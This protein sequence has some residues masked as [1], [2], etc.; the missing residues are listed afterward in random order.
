MAAA[1]IAF[2]CVF[3]SLFAGWV[4]PH[5][6]F[7]LSTLEL[8]D[9]RLPPSWMD[10]GSGKYLLGTDDQGRDMLSAVIYGARISLIVGVASVILSVL[11]GVTL[12]LLAGF[13]GG[14]IDARADAPVRRDAVLPGHSCGAA[15]CWRRTGA[16]SQRQRR[17][18]LRRAHPVDLDGAVRLGAVRAHGA[19]LH[20]GGAQ[21]GIRAGGAGDRCVVA[22]HHA[23][24]MCCPM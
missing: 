23:P 1:F 2:L 10:G 7:D 16:V 21:Q 13:R 4:A 3:S 6:P 19:R 24:A 17:A 11:V 12:G 15:D 5:N 20:A 9:A 14:W 22:A 8:S 18:G